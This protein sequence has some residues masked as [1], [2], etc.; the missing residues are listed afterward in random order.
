MTY[1]CAI[2]MVAPATFADIKGR[3][4]KINQHGDYD[5]MFHGT[6]QGQ[7]IDLTHIM[8][9]A[10]KPEK[11]DDDPSYYEGLQIE[12]DGAEDEL[13]PMIEALAR[14][15]IAENAVGNPTVQGLK[16]VLRSMEENGH[17]C[18]IIDREDVRR[19]IDGDPETAF[20]VRY[21]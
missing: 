10:E 4:R 19:M 1:T 15:V 13:P 5:Q 7:G 8:V 2:L 16:N 21:E 20:R 6:D 3:I 14:R 18:V 9:V 12:L 17:E 11:G